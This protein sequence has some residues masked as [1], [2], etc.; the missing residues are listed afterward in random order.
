[1]TTRLTS[2][3]GLLQVQNTPTVATNDNSLATTS[4]VRSAINTYAVVPDNAITSQKITDSAVTTSK[5]ANS[6]ITTSKLASN[7]DITGNNISGK[8]ITISNAVTTASITGQLLQTNIS[9]GGGNQATAISS[10]GQYQLAAKSNYIYVSNNSGVSF[11]TITS[12]SSPSPKT[13]C[14]TSTGSVMIVSNANGYAKKSIDYGVT[15][16][17]MLTIS[18]SKNI[19]MSSNGTN[20]LYSNDI[21]DSVY[22]STNSGVSFTQVTGISS[23][24]K[25]LGMSGN[26]QYMVIRGVNSYISSNGGSTWT[27]ITAVNL[28]GSYMP[29]VAISFDGKYMLA[30]SEPANTENYFSSDYGVTW[31]TRNISSAYRAAMSSDGRFMLINSYG[32]KYYYSADFGVTFTQS[33]VS[34]TPSYSQTASISDDGKYFLVVDNSGVY[35]YLNTVNI[36]T[37]NTGSLT[38][39]SMGTGVVHSNASGNLTSSTIVTN[40][41]A[42]GA[43][44]NTKIFNNAVTSSKIVDGAITSAKLHPAVDIP[45]TATATTQATTNNSTA[46]ATT[47]FVKSV[48]PIF[49]SNFGYVSVTGGKFSY[50]WSSGGT[51]IITNYNFLSKNYNNVAA[52]LNTLYGDANVITTTGNNYTFVAN[53]T[54]L[55]NL[56][57]NYSI[58]SSSGSFT[59][60]LQVYR[61]GSSVQTIYNSSLRNIDFTTETE[62]N[63]VLQAG[64]EVR[65][66]ID[67]SYASA[68][69]GQTVI[70][71]VTYN[72]LHGYLM[73]TNNLNI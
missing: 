22:L 32:E 19:V 33:T 44:T 30:T 25:G 26:G 55:Y 43:I 21:N 67:L 57:Y 28:G 64:D 24:G 71:T 49:G 46:I 40:D 2:A 37:T 7:I 63:V 31:T 65:A 9:I 72:N 20:I 36:T 14:M 11:T 59:V 8:E 6:S 69:S 48:L 10:T 12:G 60:K 51:S 66:T 50:A 70:V 68:S 35:S 4:F 34:I 41:I 73:N 61:S 53:T 54:G 18:N 27:L 42:D 47:A 45:S 62:L 17:D 56:K 23:T 29:N 13:A 58:T 5:I 3:N 39:S 38:V 1:M 52:T 15:W 16:N